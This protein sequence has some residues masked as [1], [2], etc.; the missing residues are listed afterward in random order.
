MSCR[1]PHHPFL[2]SCMYPHP[3]PQ[4]S[5]YANALSARR[6]RT[7]LPSLLCA[8]S[9]APHQLQGAEHLG[10]LRLCQYAR[11]NP[12]HRAPRLHRHRLRPLR[13]HLPPRGLR[14]LQG[15]ARGH[16]RGHQALRAHHPADCQRLRHSPT[17]GAG[18]RGR[19]RHRH[20]GPA[21]G[22]ARTRGAHG[23]A[24]QGL[25]PTRATPHRHAPS[26]PRHHQGRKTR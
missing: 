10:H 22:R 5:A 20:T 26:R 4:L 13:P 21:G 6:L 17:R 9:F 16:A 12:S 18:L 24:R 23:H 25:R 15:A 8:H 3:H 1:A 7:H 19:R 14:R 2:R 11:R